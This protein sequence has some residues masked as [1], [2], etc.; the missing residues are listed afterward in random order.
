[1][2]GTVLTSSL[3]T[4]LAAVT[5]ISYAVDDADEVS[6]GSAQAGAATV[7]Q[8]CSACHSLKYVSYNDLLGLGIS[9][10]QLDELRGDNDLRTHIAGRLPA[11][12]AKEKY[13][14]V[15]PDL[16]IMA[17]AREG[18]GDYIYRML[19][20][21][22]QT[23]DGTTDNHAYAGT[24][25]PDILGISYAT[26]A[27]TVSQIKKTAHDAMAFLEWAADPKANERIALGYYVIGYLVLLTAI[28]YLW[29]RE[30]WADVT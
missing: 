1:M 7:V 25:M 6:N 20:G 11:D 2:R 5:A 27:A 10:Q 23:A 16:S 15:P 29:K 9:K 4:G 22:Y 24:R 3:L 17:S 14:V 8:T 28:L 30:I 12:I 13:G 21:F 26:D 18:G 19:T